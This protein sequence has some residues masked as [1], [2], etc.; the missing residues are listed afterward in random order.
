MTRRWIRNST[1]STTETI[2][3]ETVRSKELRTNG[4]PNVFTQFYDELHRMQ[5][6]VDGVQIDDDG[7]P[8]YPNFED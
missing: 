4:H 6:W 2:N 8:H 7:E 1:R 3:T 5:R